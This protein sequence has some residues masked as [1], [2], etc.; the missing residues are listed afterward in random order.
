MTHTFLLL[1]LLSFVALKNS[2]CGRSISEDHPIDSNP[3]LCC[4]LCT[5]ISPSDPGLYFPPLPKVFPGRGNGYDQIHRIGLPLV[6]RL[7]VWQPDISHSVWHCSLCMAL[8]PVEGDPVNKRRGQPL[9]A[10]YI[11]VLGEGLIT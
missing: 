6:D 7:H 10:L 9:Q 8:V 3:A 1:R 2:I 4:H 5:R 11:T